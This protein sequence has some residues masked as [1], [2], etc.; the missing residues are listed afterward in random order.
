MDFFKNVKT[1]IDLSSFD[2]YF[3]FCLAY[4]EKN[5]TGADFLC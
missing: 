4:T 2:I 5:Q 1:D 3:C